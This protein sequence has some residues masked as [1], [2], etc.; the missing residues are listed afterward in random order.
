MLLACGP[1]DIYIGLGL[2]SINLRV[3]A[4]IGLVL[5]MIIGGMCM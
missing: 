2:N 3:I 4:L 1:D 5:R